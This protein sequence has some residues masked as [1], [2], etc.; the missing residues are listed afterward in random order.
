MIGYNNIAL[1]SQKTFF[2]VK[3]CSSSVSVL[4][5]S[6]SINSTDINVNDLTSDEYYFAF[7]DPTTSSSHPGWPLRN[8]L[9]A[10][11]FYW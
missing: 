10:L 2:I 11:L 8:Y 1:L 4:T 5:L 7:S 6:S 9:I 3:K